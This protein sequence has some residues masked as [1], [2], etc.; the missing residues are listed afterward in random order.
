VTL[1]APPDSDAVDI[2]LRRGRNTLVLEVWRSQRQWF[3]AGRIGRH[4]R[5]RVRAKVLVT[6]ADGLGEKYP[7]RPRPPG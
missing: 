4:R 6:L 1:H 5:T 3:F 7:P 2:E